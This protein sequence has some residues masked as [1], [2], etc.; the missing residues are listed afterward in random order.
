MKRLARFSTLSADA[1]DKLT[2]AGDTRSPDA[3][4]IPGSD[5]VEFQPKNVPE[6]LWVMR[7]AGK[8]S[9]MT[10]ADMSIRK[11]DKGPGLG[12]TAEAVKGACGAAAAAIPHTY[13]D[14]PADYITVWEG[15][16][17]AGSHA[18]GGAARGIVYAID[19]TG[20]VGTMHRRSRRDST[21]LMAITRGAR[22]LARAL[23]SAAWNRRAARSP[24]FTRSSRVRAAQT[25]ARSSCMSRAAPVMAASC[26]RMI[27]P[28]STSCAN[29]KTAGA[30]PAS[31]RCALAGTWNVPRPEERHAC[32]L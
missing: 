6:N 19:A 30:S 9:R 32:S 17:R 18:E 25:S 1:G 5:C 20:K 27:A 23:R 8:P 21:G 22:K 31:A 2:A 29:S 4:G 12:D 28:A 7:Q 24:T 10:I 15:G 3:A 13:Q 16:P 26:R 14:A 11:T